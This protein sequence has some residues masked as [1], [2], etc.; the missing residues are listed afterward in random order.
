MNQQRHSQRGYHWVINALLTCPNQKIEILRANWELIDAGFVQTIMEVAMQRQQWGDWSSANWLR[1]LATQLATGMGSS[2]SKIPKESEADRLLWQGEQQCKVS[3]FKAAFQSYQ[4]SLVLYRE[5]GNLLGESAALIGLG[6]AYDF[7]GEYLKAIDCYEQSLDILRNIGGS[8]GKAGEGTCLGNLGKTYSSLGKYHEAVD[9]QKKSLKIAQKFKNHHAVATALGNLGH[10]FFSLGRYDKAIDYHQQQLKLVREIIPRLTEG[11]VDNNLFLGLPEAINDFKKEEINALGSLGLVF[12]A[13]GQE[14]Q[15]MDHYQESLDI[16]HK[17]EARCE[18]AN[19]LANIAA[20][21]CNFSGKYDEA[22]KYFKQSLTI[23]Q[24]QE[25]DS[26]FGKAC[27]LSGLGMVYRAKGKYNQALKHYQQALS[28]AE[29]IG[30]RAWEANYLANLGMICNLL[31]QYPQAIEYEQKAVTIAKEISDHRE[32]GFTLNELGF[33]LLNYGYVTQAEN[34]LRDAMEVRES[35]RGGLKDAH[36]VS[37][38]DTQLDTYSL[39]QQALALQQKFENALEIAERGRARAFAE[40]LYE[41]VST[42]LVG[43]THDLPAKETI[44]PPNLEE[45]QQI[46]KEQKATIVEYSII[47]LDHLFIWVIKPTGE[48]TFHP[49]HLQPLRQEQNISLS[50]L[51]SQSCESLGVKEETLRGATPTTT[52]ETLQPLRYINE[53]LRQ[54]HQLLIEPIANLLPTDPNAHVIFIP[55]G[56]LFLVPF[57]ALQDATGKFLIEQHTILTSP[58]IQVLELTRKQRQRVETIH[59]LPLQSQNALV[60]GNPTM[61]TIPLIEPPQPLNSLPGAEAEANAIAS[62]LNTQPIIGEKA[63]KIDIVQQMPKARLI[64]LATHGLLDDIKQL[65]VPGAIA[66]APSDN[67]NGFLTAGEILEM[68]LNAE[69]IVLSACSSGQGKITGDGVIGLS[70]SLFAAGVPSVIVS[71]WSVGDKSTQF[72]MTEFYQNLQHGMTKAQ[73]LRQAMLTTMQRYRRPK[74]WAAFTLI[75]EAI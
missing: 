9:C 19:N 64:H 49:V 66:L 17:I 61:P 3:Q 16:A 6:I 51:V 45:I 71:L 67:D 10:N 5:I 30:T 55:Q 60:V 48:I 52:Q 31:R 25:L 59:E 23:Y 12:Y 56:S 70:R 34:A 11:K 38:F 58:S 40:L 54:L 50:D 22:I 69:L 41:R 74:S 63:T 2:L 7:F 35:L 14:K 73:S 37:L 43:V 47:N 42:N 44:D 46:A 1:N 13:I 57:P 39:L 53:P 15:A 26:L 4:Q 18:E 75:G 24:E 20:A 29:Q 68:K 65:G 62:L 36:K 33:A 21:Y 8:V 32:E 27:S 28:I 72:L